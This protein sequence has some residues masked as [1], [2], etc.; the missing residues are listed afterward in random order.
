MITTKNITKLSDLTTKERERIHQINEENLV[1]N[2]GELSLSYILN[3]FRRGDI[4]LLAY[5]NEI[6]VGYALIKKPFIEGV[7]FMNS[8]AGDIT[9][10]NY[11]WKEIT[12]DPN[13]KYIAQIAVSR[14][15][16]KYGVATA[17]VESMN[18][19]IVISNAKTKNTGSHKMHIK[20][21]FKVIGG[22]YTRDNEPYDLL[23][24]REAKCV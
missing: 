5:K 22:M 16:Q 14:D 12:K 24:Y 18:D 21:G 7:G 20:N 15:F 9:D 17:M 1:R 19:S 3:Y 6:V 10:E 23:Y 4:V 11:S 8:C 13:A 2:G